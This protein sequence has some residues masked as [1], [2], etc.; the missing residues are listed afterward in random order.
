[1]SLSFATQSDSDVPNM[2]LRPASC[3]CCTQ[4]VVIYTTFTTPLSLNRRNQL[5]SLSHQEVLPV[6]ST[7][8]WHVGPRTF[9]YLTR[10]VMV[11]VHISSIRPSRYYATKRR[12]FTPL[13]RLPCLH[14]V[15]EAQGFEMNAVIPGQSLKTFSRALACLSKIGDDLTI[16]ATKK[17][18]LPQFPCPDYF[19]LRVRLLTG[20]YTPNYSCF[21]PKF[22]GEYRVETRQNA[23]AGGVANGADKALICQVLLKT[24]TTIFR[25]K[26]NLDRNVERCELRLEDP[27]NDGGRGGGSIV[28]GDGSGECRLIIRMVCKYGACWFGYVQIQ[29]EMVLRNDLPLPLGILKTHK[30]TY[31]PADRLSAVYTKVCPHRLVVDPRLVADW[32]AHFHPKLEEVTL[33]CG[34]RAVHIKSFWEDEGGAEGEGGRREDKRSLQTE[35][36]LDVSDFATYLVQRDIELTFNL[37]EFKVRAMLGG[38]RALCGVVVAVWGSNRWEPML[39]PPTTY[40]YVIP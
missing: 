15:R 38:L 40:C 14:C 30:L 8:Y 25:S 13:L 1:M 4:Y 7:P 10:L 22:F 31:S 32:T 11:I 9:P 33:S 35:L 26:S 3:E 36:T 27:A 23:N 6:C 39:Y 17:K 18:V 19:F 5:S 24:L 2:D 37:K 16:E 28:V 29:S 21:F 34:G 20:T 12:S